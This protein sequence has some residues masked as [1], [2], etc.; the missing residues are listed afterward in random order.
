MD[1]C[2]AC[3]AEI[4][5]EDIV[6]SC[7]GFCQRRHCFHAKCVG[8]T[9]D[10]GCACLHS[11]MCWM[12]DSCN[13][14]IQN[15]RFSKPSPVLE[16]NDWATKEEV[17]SLKLEVQRMSEALSTLAPNST[18]CIRTSNDSSSNRLAAH[19]A[20]VLTPP[21]TSTQI[22]DQSPD[23]RNNSHL[24]LFISNIANDVT[25]DEIKMMVCETIGAEDVLTVKRL[26]SPWKQLSTY[27]YVS[28]KVV[29][30]AVY[31]SSALIASKWPS[32]VRCREFKDQSSPVWRPSFRAG[33]ISF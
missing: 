20:P 23:D 12:C 19:S 6:V 25:E 30:D 33:H 28:F 26:V 32:G 4:R 21:L 5:V 27:D 3:I 8:L 10:E 1:N 9:Y 15:G 17:H 7:G 18:T 2:Y 29:V 11:N 31:R 14:S 13:N 16:T 22:D 24:Q